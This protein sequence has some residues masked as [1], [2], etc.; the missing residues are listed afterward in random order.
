MKLT[1]STAIALALALT[2]VSGRPAAVSASSV[3]EDSPRQDQHV[4][5]QN[6]IKNAATTNFCI[7]FMGNRVCPCSW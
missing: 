3:P 4:A 5:S 1:A 7:K 2:A 6:Q